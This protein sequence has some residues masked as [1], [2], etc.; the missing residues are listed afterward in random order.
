MKSRTLVCVTAIVLFATLATSVRLSAQQ[1][2][3]KL[4]DIGTLGGPSAHGPGN[5]GGSPLLNNGGIVA[6]TAETS[7]PDPNAP[8]CGNPDCFL[9]HGFR[10]QDG[11][12]TD[13]GALP[14]GNSS[15]AHAIN[16]HGWIVGIS[17][18]GEVDP[19]NPACGFP[20]LCPQFRTV[21]WK[22]GEIIDVGTLGEG[23]ES[24]PFYVNNGGQVVGS[25]TINTTPDRF[26]F[27]GAQTHAFI[28]Q[29]G[30]MRDLGTL[31][32]L[33]S[34]A[35]FGCNNQRS[36]LV[37]GGSFTNS[38]PNATTGVP[39]SHPFLWHNGRMTDLGTL[40]GTL[41]GAQC[42][43]NQGQVIGQSNLAGD[44]EQHAFSWEHGTLTDL[45]TLGGSFSF[46]AW[47]N[48]EGEAVGVATT[49]GD[50]AFHATLWRNGRIT[51]L[52]SLAGD[53][54]SVADAINS[55]HQIVGKSFSCD[56][57]SI[58][59][60]LWD[61]GSIINLNAAIPEPININDRGEI[62]GV[63]RPP[64]CDDENLC[65]HQFL[66]IPCASGQGCEGRDSFSAQI[67][68]AAITTTLTQRREMTKEFVAHLRARLAQRYHIRGLR[69]SPRD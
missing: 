13:L 45:G 24:D 34:F 56:F 53:C 23:L 32:G 6:G 59:A 28:W 44:M 38:T 26:S 57:S 68:S 48:N 47:L 18:N 3:Y 9:S 50:Q 15:D 43:N 5:G 2:R 33:D 42:A 51:D 52:G 31:G 63:G 27:L 62:A 14:G 17:T 1:T 19:S 35:S 7:T 46:A 69:A 29:N 67:E 4:I 60:V 40:G 37:A 41:A 30:V 11:V 12:L 64:G 25:S 55:K 58:R 66:L 20:P 16:A 54:F 61:K 39:T 8:N 21:L 65:G 36:D 49:A 10:W 22:D